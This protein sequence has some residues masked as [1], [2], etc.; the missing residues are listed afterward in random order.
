MDF[1]V[2]RDKLF[3]ELQY[4][5]GIVER[6][7]MVPIL[8]N[9]LLETSGNTLVI[10]ATDLDVT[11]ECI[12]PAV[13]KVSGAQTVPARKLFEVV[14]FLPES[15]VHFKVSPEENWIHIVCE[16]A[17]FKIAS[18]SKENFPDVPTMEGKIITLPT[19]T[20]NYMVSRCIFAITEE[21]SRYT[22]SGALM[23]IGSGSVTFVTTDGHRLASISWNLEIPGVEEEI[24]VLIPKKALVE[25]SKLVAENVLNVEFAFSENHLAFRVGERFLVSRILSGQFPN[26]EMVIPRENDKEVVLNTRNLTS[27]VRRIV[28]MADE[29]LRAVRFL[30]RKG[31]LDISSESIEFG[32][33]KETVPAQYEGEEI[34]I[35]FN[36]EYLLSFLNVLDSE[37]VMLKL[38]DNDTQGLLKPNPQSEYTYQYVVMP[39]KL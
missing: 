28:V 30:V 39:M 6:K 20:L 14:R 11:L 21:E 24:R 18:L 3:A 4:V 33:A 38:R 22:L 25:L 37:E 5:Q 34:V 9:L 7:T 32:E 8:S 10:T 23:I 29:Q 36:A 27:A 35:G 13:V 19:E 31:Q 1:T 26:Y 12:C 2:S 17:R 16:R 15:E